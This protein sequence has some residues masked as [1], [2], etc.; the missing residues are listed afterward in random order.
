MADTAASDTAASDTLGFEV[1]SLIETDNKVLEQ[2]RKDL[3]EEYMLFMSRVL[4]ERLSPQ[5]DGGQ[6][7]FDQLRKAA[8]AAAGSGKSS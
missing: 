7:P 6:S 4:K 5:S 8:S 2:V 3:S 1:D